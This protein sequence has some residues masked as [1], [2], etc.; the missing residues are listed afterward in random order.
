MP[1]VWE[2]RIVE[3]KCTKSKFSD[4][5]EKHGWL[6][7]YDRPNDK[8]SEIGYILP[9]GFS[10]TVYFDVEVNFRVLNDVTN[11]CMDAENDEN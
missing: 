10:L 11:V 2:A 4:Y 8:G 5:A 1:E 7:L 3:M 9:H 6:E